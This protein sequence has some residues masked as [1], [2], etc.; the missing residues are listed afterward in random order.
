M[1]LCIFVLKLRIS[2]LL[3]K[4]PL[5]RLHHSSMRLLGRDQI[6]NKNLHMQGT[7]HDTRSLLLDQTLK[8]PSKSVA[9]WKVDYHWFVFR[10]N[11]CE[12]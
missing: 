2:L 12:L 1:R 3:G 10:K 8:Y 11:A 9:E 5:Q 4:N 6:D 7:H